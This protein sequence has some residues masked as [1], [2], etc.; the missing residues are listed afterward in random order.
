M[1]HRADRRIHRNPGGWLRKAIED[2]YAPPKGYESS[3]N[4]EERLRAQAEQQRHQAEANQAKREQQRRDEEEREAID[5]YLA[6][7]A[8]QERSALEAEVIAR[9]PEG[10]RQTCQDPAVARFRNILVRS[11]VHEYVAQKLKEK[12]A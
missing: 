7:L 5:R 12:Q 6:T 11:A 10:L 9:A 8:P 2:D 1:V 3:A 4:R